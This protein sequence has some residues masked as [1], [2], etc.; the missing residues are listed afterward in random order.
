[1][2]EPSTHDSYGNN[3]WSPH[4]FVASIILSDGVEL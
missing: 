1:L 3:G 4:G 2:N